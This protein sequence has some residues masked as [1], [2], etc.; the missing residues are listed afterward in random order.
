MARSKQVTVQPPAVPGS[1]DPKMTTEI[2]NAQ[3][4]KLRADLA[5]YAADEAVRARAREDYRLAEERIESA[6]DPTVH[7]VTDT[8]AI[9]WLSS[10]NEECRRARVTIPDSWDRPIIFAKGDEQLGHSTC[11]EV[12]VIKD[13]DWV[14]KNPQCLVFL[15]GDAIDSATKTSPGSIRENTQPPMRQGESYVEL[16]KRIAKR[17]IG[18][19][20]GN[21]ERRIDKALDEGG[22]GVRLIAKG[23]SSDDH[24]IPYSGGLLLIDVVWRGFLWTFTLFHGA[25]AAVTPGSKIQRMQRNM[26]LTD[27]MITLSGHLH[28]E[29]KTSRRYVKRS[30]DGEIKIV[31]HVSL[32]CGTYLKYIGS[33]GEVGG[34][35]PVGPD[36]IVIELMPDGKYKDTFKGESDL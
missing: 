13:I 12:R 30:H 16:H 29:A 36:M 35:P 17:I 28:E 31:K 5:I 34:M 15:L 4:R 23:L 21:H 32:Q 25:G 33:Y 8:V 14:E 3:I 22:A 20:G 9:E 24:K 11:D 27:S 6:A 7:R 19:V 26:L 18:Y 1:N 2:L 10:H